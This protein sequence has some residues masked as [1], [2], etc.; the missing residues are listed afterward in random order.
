M[1]TQAQTQTERRAKK[2]WYITYM[3]LTGTCIVIITAFISILW[4]SSASLSKA[5]ERINANTECCD[6][7]TKNYEEMQNDINDIKVQLSG[8]TTDLE[9]IKK[10]NENIE[11]ILKVIAKE[12]LN[13]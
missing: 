5:E 11:E 2:P 3:P 6:T 9:W 8:Q 12:K 1:A 13:K 4:T 7:V 10:S